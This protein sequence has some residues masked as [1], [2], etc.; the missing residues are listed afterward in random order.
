M[1]RCT[2][3]FVAFIIVALGT[4]ACHR[5]QHRIA[6]SNSA[7]CTHARCRAK[8]ILPAV[9]PGRTTP[10]H[11]AVPLGRTTGPYHWA[12]PLA[13]PL[14]RTTGGAL[15]WRHPRARQHTG[16]NRTDH[17]PT[18]AP[19]GCRRLRHPRGPRRPEDTPDLDTTTT[20]T[21][22]TAISTQ[23]RAPS[24]EQ[25]DVDH[26]AH[27]HSTD[28]AHSHSTQSQSPSVSTEHR[29][30]RCRPRR[31][32]HHTAATAVVVA[33]GARWVKTM[34]MSFC[35]PNT[36]TSSLSSSSSLASAS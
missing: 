9:P 25:R 5:P 19:Q 34:S 16:P 35:T 30:A 14:G 28:T 7:R 23:H 20:T 21:T 26:A 17:P 22:T 36:I 33:G 29:A 1:P 13:V 24:T 18:R 8:G 31:T 10:Y 3:P 4:R 27:S 32:H 2:G 6:S 11:W 12:V 15:N